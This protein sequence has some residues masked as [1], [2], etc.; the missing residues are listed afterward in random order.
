MKAGGSGTRRGWEG[1]LGTGS[2]RLPAMNL[3]L[4]IAALVARLTG[5]LRV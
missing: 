1:A 5:S 3:P 2:G 4:L